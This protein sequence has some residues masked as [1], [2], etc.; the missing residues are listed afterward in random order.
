MPATTTITVTGDEEAAARL[1]AIAAASGGAILAT[2]VSAG[3]LVIEAD[4]KRRAP[5]LTGNLRRSIHH[6]VVLQTESRAV[7]T[8]GTDVEYAG[9]VEFGTSRMAAQPYLRP[10]ADENTAAIEAAVS[11]V[12]DAALAVG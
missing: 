9:Y 3:A 6:E 10:A 1:R 8:V 4:A 5:V 2:A 11:A 12:I 7:A